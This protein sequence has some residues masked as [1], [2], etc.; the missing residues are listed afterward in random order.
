MSARVPGTVQIPKRGCTFQAT[1]GLIPSLRRVTSQP[2][3]LLF[4]QRPFVCS[5]DPSEERNGE[6][7]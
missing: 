3:V 7:A 1:E 2:H 4:N 6:R 5:L